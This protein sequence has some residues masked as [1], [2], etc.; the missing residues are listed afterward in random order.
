MID[1]S[2]ITLRLCLDLKKSKR[3]SVPLHNL[4]NLIATIYD[5][6]WDQPAARVHSGSITLKSQRAEAAL[7]KIQQA[8]SLLLQVKLWRPPLMR[9]HIIAMKGETNSTAVNEL[10]L[11]PKIV[12]SDGK[13][14]LSETQWLLFVTYQLLLAAAEVQMSEAVVRWGNYPL[15]VKVELHGLM[16]RTRR[17]TPSLWLR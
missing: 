15:L 8:A 11:P 9:I 14:V 12:T 6:D 1:R 17:K 13:V 4:H 16:D 2:P 5:H 7:M 10:R 3:T